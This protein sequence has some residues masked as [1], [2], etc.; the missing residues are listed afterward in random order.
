MTALESCMVI[1]FCTC[2]RRSRF[3]YGNTQVHFCTYCGCSPN[4]NNRVDILCS[5]SE[6][7]KEKA[8]KKSYPVYEQYNLNHQLA[9]SLHPN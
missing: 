4:G 8:L 7:Q 3:L 2:L 5:G 9:Y 1:H 6:A